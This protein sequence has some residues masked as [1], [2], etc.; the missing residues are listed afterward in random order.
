MER[1]ARDASRLSLVLFIPLSLSL[2]LKPDTQSLSLTLPNHLPIFSIFSFP[3]TDTQSNRQTVTATAWQGIL[4]LKPPF[5][6]MILLPGPLIHRFYPFCFSL[7]LSNSSACLMSSPFPL[8]SLDTTFECNFV[9]SLS[10]DL[11]NPLP[12]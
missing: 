4:K 1:R 7:S 2:S 10:L 9:L 11:Q 12:A 6:K 3:D 8:S 5:P